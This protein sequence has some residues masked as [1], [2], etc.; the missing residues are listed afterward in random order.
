MADFWLNTVNLV[1]GTTSAHALGRFIGLC[2]LAVPSSDPMELKLLQGVCKL[3]DL[4]DKPAWVLW[5]TIKHSQ[6]L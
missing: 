5:K 4:G 1:E 3:P 2:V 6:P